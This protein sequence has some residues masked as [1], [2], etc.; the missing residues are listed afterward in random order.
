MIVKFVI[1]NGDEILEV[2]NAKYLPS[3]GDFVDI[4]RLQYR[5]RDVFHNIETL[6]IHARIDAVIVHLE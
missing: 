6:D 1:D 3:K 5:V 4:D 2:H